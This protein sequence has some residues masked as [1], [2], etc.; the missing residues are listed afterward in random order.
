MRLA[1]IGA[2][3]VGRTLGRRWVDSGHDVTFGMR[4][5]DSAD[6]KSMLNDFKGP[7]TASAASNRNAASRA[8][9]VF[10]TTPWN[11]TEEAIRQCGDLAGKI[12]VDCTNP[13]KLGATEEMLEV[14]RKDSAGERVAAWADGAV[15]FKS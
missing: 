1:I 11:A 13:V 12:V 8:E 15:V 2:G 14:G 6:A 9:V 10:L 4:E 5:P 3:N 7:G